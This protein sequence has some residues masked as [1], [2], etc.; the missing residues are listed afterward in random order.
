MKEL[1]LVLLAALLAFLTGKA[2]KDKQADK[3]VNDAIDER[4]KAESE[5]LA[6]DPDRAV[7][8]F[9][10]MLDDIRAGRASD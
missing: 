9:N 6:N 2:W 8:E 10:D 5:A 4:E 7:D 1:L 3:A